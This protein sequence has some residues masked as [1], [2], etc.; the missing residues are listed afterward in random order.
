MTERLLNA[1]QASARLGISARSFLRNRAKLCAVGL[2]MVRLG[3]RINYRED[4][5]N[6]LIRYA[7][8]NEETLY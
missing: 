3:K 4:S 2:Q 1:E 6:R 8:E 7:A 5:I